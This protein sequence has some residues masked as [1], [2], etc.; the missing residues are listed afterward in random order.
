MRFLSLLTFLVLAASRLAAQCNACDPDPSCTSAD[1]FPTICPDLLPDAETDAAYE[2]VI[3]FFLPAQVT[4][5]GSGAVADLESVTITTITGVPIGLQVELSD[6]DGVYEPMAG[7]TSGCATLCG[8]PVWP[9]DFVIEISISA[10][11]SVFGF[12]QT[13]NDSFTFD[14]HIEPGAGGTST[15][16]VSQL[17][18]CDS[19]TIDLAATAAGTPDQTTTYSWDLGNG[20]TSSADSLSVTYGEPGEY[21]V[22]LNT[23]ISEPVLT[24]IQV[25]STGGAGLDDFFTPPDLYFIL[26][27]GSGNTVYTSPEVTD[28]NDPSWN[29][30]SIPVTNPPYN[31]AFWDADA[32]GNDDSMGTG[33]LMTNTTGPFSFAASPT[34]GVS[35]INLQTVLTLTDTIAIT[36]GTAPILPPPVSTP[37]WMYAPVD[38]MLQFSWMQADST[39]T[40]GPDSTFFPPA[41]GWVTYSAANLLGCVGT[42]DSALFCG[43]T[44]PVA[45]D[46]QT[47]SSSPEA[48]L[49]NPALD[50][51]L[52]TSADGTIGDTTDISVLFPPI[53]GWYSAE[54]WDSYGCPADADSLLVCWPLPPLEI[55]Q[56]L[57]GDLTTTPGYPI[58]LWYVNGSAVAGGDWW[59]PALGPGVYT[60]EATDHPDCPVVVSPEWIYVGLEGPAVPAPRFQVFPNPFRE[61]IQITPPTDIAG[62]WTVELRDATG[63]KVR[64]TQGTVG[65]LS[66]SGLASGVYFLTIFNASGPEQLRETHR[67]I[68]P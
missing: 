63:R 40:I 48:L 49:A 62:N 8:T 26:Q 21:N 11:A 16:T 28:S 19:L 58:Y 67:L 56:E 38:S 7:Q 10:V 60:V 53:S 31:I 54:G 51:F 36:V 22:V 50:T 61:F 13:V 43:L 34:F 6:P 42:S 2:Q 20:E 68:R 66:T 14:L 3:T 52:W 65:S 47:N 12:Q 29:G 30:L 44:P 45:L 18:G 9:G 33:T 46:L 41:N 32:I 35:Y 39:W 5:P 15:F 37:D 17:S 64:E 4:D 25:T 24:S 27:D 57:N 55:F 59:L 23:D 1:G